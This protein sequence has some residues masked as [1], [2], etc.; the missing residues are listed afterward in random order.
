VAGALAAVRIGLAAR[1]IACSCIGGGGGVEVE[2]LGEDDDWVEDFVAGGH[3]DLPF[4]GVA[5]AADE[6]WGE[7]ADLL[8]DGAAYFLGI[9]IILLLEAVSAGDAAAAAVQHGEGHTRDHLHQAFREYAPAE[10]LHVTRNMIGYP[11]G[12][13]FPEHQL[14]LSGIHQVI[15]ELLDQSDAVTDLRI[16]NIQH[17]R[18]FIPHG[19]SAG[20]SSCYYRKPLAYHLLEHSDIVPGVPAGLIPEAIG[21]HCNP[22]ALLIDQLHPIADGIHH[23]HKGFSNLRMLELGGTAMEERHFL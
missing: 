10:L 3:L 23:L 22:A 14:H 20:G 19:K 17:V 21:N 18:I 4:A 2:G 8:E 7:G 12:V 5:F 1:R 15:E 16:V 11:G 6:V 13:V 9:F